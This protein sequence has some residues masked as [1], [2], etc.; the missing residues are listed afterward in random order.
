MRFESN[1]I[2]VPLDRPSRPNPERVRAEWHL[3]CQGPR[4]VY[5]YDP[6]LYP[7]PA[8]VVED[9]LAV[10]Y[11]YRGD[12]RRMQHFMGGLLEDFTVWR[13]GK[14]VATYQAD[15]MTV[16]YQNEHLAATT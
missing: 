13:S 3:V 8:N 16:E 11:D 12:A 10:V 1:A 9:L 5:A 14:L 7:E 15:A 6:A 2:I 4:I